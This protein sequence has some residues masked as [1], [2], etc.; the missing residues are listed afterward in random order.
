M[1]EKRPGKREE[2]KP[3]R[4][5]AS[6][7][8]KKRADLPGPATS[9]QI[10]IDPE[11]TGRGT[12]KERKTDA[13]IKLSRRIAD[14]LILLG[15]IAMCVPAAINGYAYYTQW[16]LRRSWESKVEELTNK[17]KL[18]K[19]Q[20]IFLRLSEDP[21]TELAKQ[22]GIAYLVIPRMA[23]RSVIVEG[24]DFHDLVKGPG[25]LKGTAFPGEKGNC[26]VSGHRTMYGAPFGDLDELTP[27]AD[28]LIYTNDHIFHYV[29]SDKK[30]VSPGDLSVIDNPEDA[31]LTLTTCDPRFSDRQRLIIVARLEETV[32]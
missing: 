14:G 30:I 26:V 1:A 12:A 16:C 8:G 28:I 31:C 13:K 32:R 11:A 22:N 5:A 24:A 4:P 7:P 3:V 17:I 19:G 29:V 21:Q 10:A 2:M 9:E 6:L 23:L 27:G 25:H 18:P 20:K 15:I